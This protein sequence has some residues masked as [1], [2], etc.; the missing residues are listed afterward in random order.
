MSPPVRPSAEFLLLTRLARPGF[1]AQDA[2]N[3]GELAARADLEAFAAL[4]AFHRCAGHVLANLAALDHRILPEPM[5]RRCLQMA[6]GGRRR[7]EVQL[8]QLD[9]IGAAFE[10]Q[11]VEAMVLKGPAVSAALF[12]DPA[13]RVLRDLDVMVRAEDALAAV[14]A[15]DGL[16]W[17]P[18]HPALQ[19]PMTRH[20]MRRLQS[21]SN[22][23]AFQNRDAP[24][25][26]VELHWRPGR[27]QVEFP[28]RQDALWAQARRIKIAGRRWP[29]LDRRHDAVFLAMHG[30]KHEWKRLHW[31]VDIA[32]LMQDPRTDWP[33]VA[34]VCAQTGLGRSVRLAAR[35]AE[36][37]LDAAWPA[38]LE[39]PSAGERRAAE[40]IRRRRFHGA[41]VHDSPLDA[42]FVECRNIA[43]VGGAAGR[44]RLVLGHLQPGPY[45]WALMDAPRWAEGLYYP[46]RLARIAAVLGANALSRLRPG[47][48]AARPGA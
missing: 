20:R 22:N 10:A 37:V 6:R 45:E 46:L 2:L 44:A 42:F 40:A 30:C 31:L 19:G 29:T 41:P 14:A 15:L 16:G 25:F 27:F 17:R 23:I 47:S 7:T 28:V 4:A 18:E 26:F 33:G 38:G 5:H 3:A 9:A 35:L 48:R 36:T 43:L 11:G 32:A 39:A 24:N 21:W 34:A 13:R 12:G 1:N 8:G